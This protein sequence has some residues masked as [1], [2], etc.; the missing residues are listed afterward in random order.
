[1]ADFENTLRA[2]SQAIL[3]RELTEN[4]RIEFLELAGAI[5]MGSVQ[6]YLYMLMIFKRNEDR[7]TGQMVSFKKEMKARF[8][9][10]GVL[11][12]KIDAT[13]GTTLADMLGKG[14]EKIG[15]AM[16]RDIESSAKEILKK[17]GDYHFL[18]GQVLT[19]CVVALM[20]TLGYWF[21]SIDVFEIGN[22]RSF[23][24]AFLWFPAGGLAF[25]CGAIYTFAWYL[26]HEGRIG[27]FPTYMIKFTLQ[28]LILL[29]LLLRVLP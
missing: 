13:L 8:D 21:G 3:K 1:M 27:M 25:I 12:K 16:G 4:E 11:E 24:R 5:G 15:Y 18:R 14:A 28:V 9:E 20:A 26:D 29:V 17:N 19:V 23:F 22:G 2:A 10:M 6:D 7:I